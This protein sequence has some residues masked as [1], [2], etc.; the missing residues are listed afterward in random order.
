[1]RWMLVAVMVSGAGCA[2]RLYVNVLRP[3]A[4]N[5][6]PAKTLAVTQIE[7]RLDAREVVL[8]ELDAQINATGY[9]TVSERT[10]APVLPGETALRLTVLEYS[11][12]PDPA[13]DKHAG[14]IGNVALAATLTDTNGRVVMN[15][16]EYRNNSRSDGGQQDA[17]GLTTRM[18]VSALLE[19][20][21]PSF[22]RQAIALDEEDVAQRAIVDRARQG[23]IKR[24]IEDERDLLG[25][26]PTAAAAFNLGALLDSQGE[27]AEALKLYDQAIQQQ[28]KELYVETR[29]ACARRLADEQALGH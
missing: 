13:S 3:A 17:L 23:D 22:V 21:T 12:T 5:L 28:M 4:V 19:D 15:A 16:K 20:I 7:G 14:W 8:R 9:F 1:M 10:D 27:Y 6:G 26:A 29:G 25:R 24:A 2:P 11:A 18:A